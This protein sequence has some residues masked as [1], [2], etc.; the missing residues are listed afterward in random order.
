MKLVSFEFKFAY[1]PRGMQFKE[2]TNATL[3]GIRRMD[4]A[5]FSILI[6]F[7]FPSFWVLFKFKFQN[8]KTELG[9]IK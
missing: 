8:Y 3:S 7:L 5:F 9:L 6:S 1:T 4:M 2:R